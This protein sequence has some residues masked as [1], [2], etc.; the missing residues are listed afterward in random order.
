MEDDSYTRNEKDYATSRY[1]ASHKKVNRNTRKFKEQNDPEI[2]DMIEEEVIK[3]E[4]LMELLSEDAMLNKIFENKN[5]DEKDEEI[6]EEEN[7]KKEWISEEEFK[8]QKALK[9]N[10][11]LL[12]KEKRKEKKNRDD[13]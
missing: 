13:K 10:K 5:K 3:N 4:E 1:K 9:N 6:E 12:K 8:R 7:E 11:H 2:Q